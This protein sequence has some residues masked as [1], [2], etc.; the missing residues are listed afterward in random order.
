MRI[1]IPVPEREW[2]EC[3][4]ELR[5]SIDPQLDNTHS[6]LIVYLFVRANGD[7]RDLPHS[8]N[9]A[10]VAP[11]PAVKAIARAPQN[12]TR[13][14]GLRT[15]APPVHAPIMPSRASSSSKPISAPPRQTPSPAES[16]GDDPIAMGKTIT[17]LVTLICLRLDQDG[18]AAISALHFTRVQS[19]KA[20]SGRSYRVALSGRNVN[21]SKVPRP[22][23]P[24]PSSKKQQPI[25][26]S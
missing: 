6:L 2:I 14:I 19:S 23:G 3:V 13:I 15:S 10:E 5:D 18:S 11:I 17:T 21:E 9:R 20:I 16:A 4:E 25:V 12:V 1:E 26:W 7:H 22:A 24:V 8:G